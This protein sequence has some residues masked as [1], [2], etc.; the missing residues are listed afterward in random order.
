MGM[1]DWI[2]NT[3]KPPQPITLSAPWRRETLGA[4]YCSYTCYE[5]A[6]KGMLLSHGKSKPC[7]F[8]QQ[9]VT[10]GQR[11]VV[12]MPFL[13][14]PNLV[15]PKCHTKAERWNAARTDCSLCGKKYS[16]D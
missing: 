7:C 9:V 16:Q 2:R 11:G 6:G 13:T 14:E 5:N 15:C 12:Y 8:C 4:I 10:Y 3:I 1:F